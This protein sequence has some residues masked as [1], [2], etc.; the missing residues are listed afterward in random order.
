M[1]SFSS[2]ISLSNDTLEK[3]REIG[4]PSLSLLLKEK[5]HEEKA[6][7][8]NGKNTE[9]KP[10]EMRITL[11]AGLIEQIYSEEQE[12]EKETLEQLAWEKDYLE[13][14]ECLLAQA[15]EHFE[16]NGRRTARSSAMSVTN[17]KKGQREIMEILMEEAGACQK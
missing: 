11:D 9:E 17:W 2:H 13:N 8:Q 12:E 14:K 4:S 16:K 10:Q 6:K 7:Q 3:W 1:V 15:R 5:I